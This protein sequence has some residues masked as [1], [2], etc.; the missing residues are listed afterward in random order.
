MAGDAG[1]RPRQLALALVVALFFALLGCLL[2]LLKSGVVG[3]YQLVLVRALVV[4]VAQHGLKQV[5]VLG[6]GRRANGEHG[7]DEHAHG[8]LDLIDGGGAGRKHDAPG[9]DEQDGLL[10]VVALLNKAVVDVALVGLP[11][12]NVGALAAHDGAKRVDDGYAGHDER[13]DERGERGGAAHVEQRDGTQRKAQKQRSRVA[14]EDARGVEVVAQKGQA[15]A[16]QRDGERGGIDAAREHGH[17]EHRERCDATDSRRQAVKTVDEVDDIGERHQVDH[18]D[19]VGEPA[20]HDIARGKRVDD[21][22]DAQAAH[23]GDERG[24]DLTGQLLLGLELVDVVDRA[25]R[26]DDGKRKRKYGVAD[27][28]EG[29]RHQNGR[30]AQVPGA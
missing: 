8:D 24:E 11:N 29:M 12:A 23:A 2:L 28:Q 3:G 1:A 6:E 5:Q 9:I 7:K 19:G 17:R 4:M 15:G 10:L 27:V 20:K 26:K 13:D 14:Q 25:G 30:P 21:D 16:K 18:G 22:A